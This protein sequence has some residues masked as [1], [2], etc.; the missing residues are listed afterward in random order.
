M[1]WKIKGKGAPPTVIPAGGSSNF[2]SPD[3]QYGGGANGRMSPHPSKGAM[4]G[5]APNP[6]TSQFAPKKRAHFP[7]PRSSRNTGRNVKTTPRYPTGGG[8]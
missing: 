5:Q 2:N 6:T 8:R 1:K 7:M 4:P 3:A